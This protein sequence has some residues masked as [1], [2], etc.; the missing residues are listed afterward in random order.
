[1][2]VADPG[3]ITVKDKATSTSTNSQVTFSNWALD[4]TNKKTYAVHNIDG[5]KSDFG[6]IW[7]RILPIV[8]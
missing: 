5:L 7:K 6:D 2:T 8:L 1:M 3:T 4:I